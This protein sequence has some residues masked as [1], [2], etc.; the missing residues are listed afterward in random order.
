[1]NT[2]SWLRDPLLSPPV[3]SVVHDHNAHAT[4]RNRVRV[5]PI[6][7]VRSVIVVSLIVAA[8]NKGLLSLIVV[9]PDSIVLIVC[10]TPVRCNLVLASLCSVGDPLLRLLIAACRYSALQTSRGILP[11]LLSGGFGGFLP[12]LRLTLLPNF[13]CSLL[14]LEQ[15]WVLLDGGFDSFLGAYFYAGRLLNGD[16][17][18]VLNCRHVSN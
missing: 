15:S 5:A 13:L 1:M 18:S 9:S 3:A 16:F 10:K 11:Q 7:L 8:K 17:Q 2:H 12:K 4:S 14:S 6:L